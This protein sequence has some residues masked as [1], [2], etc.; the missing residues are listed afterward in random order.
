MWHKWMIRKSCWLALVREMFG[1]C[2]L[3]ANDAAV[4]GLERALIPYASLGC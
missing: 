3:R 4:I 1:N 2:D